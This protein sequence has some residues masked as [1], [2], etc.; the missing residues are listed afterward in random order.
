MKRFALTAILSVMAVFAFNSVGIA[1]EVPDF[2]TAAKA[3]FYDV[4]SF[5]DNPPFQTIFTNTAWLTKTRESGCCTKQVVIAYHK[6][7]YHVR[8]ADQF[9][10]LKAILCLGERTGYTSIAAERGAATHHF[11]KNRL[12]IIYRHS[13]GGIVWDIFGLKDQEDTRQ[14]RMSAAQFVSLYTREDCKRLA[15][16]KDF[17][18]QQQERWTIRQKHLATKGHQIPGGRGFE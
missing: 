1:A 5:K 18:R 9:D 3:N 15:L 11:I 7:N 12:S 8:G 16:R 14:T 6:K 4:K 13:A 10:R 2:L 17:F